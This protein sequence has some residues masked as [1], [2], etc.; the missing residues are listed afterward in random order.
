MHRAGIRGALAVAKELLKLYDEM[1]YVSLQFY[2]RTYYD[3]FQMA[4]MSRATLDQATALITAA[5]D[6]KMSIVGHETEEILRYKAL[7]SDPSKHRNY[8]KGR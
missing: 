7:I 8:L 1:G 2:S 4:V 3:A 6:A 5:H